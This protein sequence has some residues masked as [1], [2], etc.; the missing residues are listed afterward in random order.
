MSSTQEPTPPA[1]LTVD[2]LLSVQRSLNT[3]FWPFVVAFTVKVLADLA[4]VGAFRPR[5]PAAARPYF[6]ADLA[7]SALL[8]AA[9]VTL[10]L[11]LVRASRM[12]GRSARLVVGWFLALPV[13]ILAIPALGGAELGGFG[14]MI[15]V[16]ANALLASPAAIWLSLR[17][18]IEDRLEE[19]SRIE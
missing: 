12:L 10:G 7:A 16:F 8:L 14:F 2:T 6:V 17:R 15:F 18:E 13:V 19:L 1:E 3:V 5:Q 9:F 4:Y 11:G